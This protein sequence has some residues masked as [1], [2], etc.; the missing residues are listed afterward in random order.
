MIGEYNKSVII[1]YIGVIL[2]IFGIFFAL[3]NYF[4]ASFLCLIF[5]GICD[6][7]DGPVARKCKRSE[8]AKQFGVQLDS[9][10]DVFSFIAFPSVLCLFLLGPE[11]GLVCIPYVICGIIRLAWFNVGANAGNTLQYFQ[12]LPVTYSAL[13]LP[14]YYLLTLILPGVFFVGGFAFLYVLI[15]LAFVINVKI[16]KPRGM[17][18]LFFGV[19]S[20]LV[21]AGIIIF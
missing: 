11:V 12:G 6:M 3:K 9:L 15:A 4:D 18:Y 14:I 20:L 21:S 1:T 13:I 16:K 7:I 2:S 17:A 19:L 5:A 10:A 8:S